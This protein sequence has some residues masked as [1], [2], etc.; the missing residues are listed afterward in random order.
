MKLQSTPTTTMASTSLEPSI[1][2]SRIFRALLA[3]QRSSWEQGVAAQ[4]LLEW[5]LSPLSE[6]LSASI[7]KE[8]LLE[9]LYGLAHDAIV[10]QG[11]DGRLAVCLNGSGDSDAGAVDPCCIGE[12]LYHLMRREDVDHNRFKE[13]TQSMLDYI[14]KQCPKASVGVAD[15][16]DSNRLLLSHRTDAVEIWSDTVYMLPSFLAAAAV[17][18]VQIQILPMSDLS[19]HIRAS[20]AQIVLAAKA[21]QATSGEWSHIYDLKKQEF[22]RA[23][24]WGV[25]NGWACA[26]IVRVFRIFAG[27]LV[28][29][30]SADDMNFIMGDKQIMELL[31]TSYDILRRTLEA[32]FKHMRPDGLFHDI[33][34]DPSSFVETNFSQQLA[35]TVYRLL[36]LQLHSPPEVSSCF[37]FPPLSPDLIADWESKADAMYWAAVKQTDRWGFVNGVCGSPTFDKAGTAAEGQAFGVLIEIARGEYL[38]NKSGSA[39]V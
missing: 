39:A 29:N 14:W 25:G 7:S 4:A 34:D 2:I 19:S 12:T 31:Q 6:S 8:I 13:A 16:E 9:Y 32:C 18:F 35:Y 30:E 28:D 27:A 22:K 21:L 20:L 38:R 11:V 1:R 24:Y 37:S 26:G 17:H 5:Y 10:R 36:D 3:C 23:A 15:E 33:L